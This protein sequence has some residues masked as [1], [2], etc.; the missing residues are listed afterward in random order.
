MQHIISNLGGLRSPTQSHFLVY[1]GHT[2][3][4][5]SYG[6]NLSAVISNG[7]PSWEVHHVLLLCSHRQKLEFQ[8]SKLYSLNSFPICMLHQGYQGAIAICP[9]CLLDGWMWRNMQDSYIPNEY[10]PVLPLEKPS[11]NQSIAKNEFQMFENA[12]NC[13][14]N[15]D[16][17]KNFWKNNEK[18]ALVDDK[19]VFV[20]IVNQY[21][22]KCI[23]FG[24]D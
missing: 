9:K 24:T 8:K 18:L 13:M 4:A 21:S 22:P 20:D 2:I 7:K 12:R 14:V 23:E 15:L 10:W 3:W 6:S 19:W 1:K 11:Q 5:I 16:M 17:V